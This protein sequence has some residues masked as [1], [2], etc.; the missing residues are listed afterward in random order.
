MTFYNSWVHRTQTQH[1]C[2]LCFH[3]NF[4]MYTD[5]Y[6]CILMY[7]SKCNKPLLHVSFPCTIWIPSRY[8]QHPSSYHA[9]TIPSQHKYL[10]SQI[11]MQPSPQVYLCAHADIAR[12]ESSECPTWNAY[13][14]LPLTSGSGVKSATPERWKSFAYKASNKGTPCE[15]ARPSEDGTS[16]EG[17][18][19][20]CQ[21]DTLP[22]MGWISS[23]EPIC[24]C[25][26]DV[27]QLIALPS[28]TYQPKLNQSFYF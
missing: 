26:S 23:N 22:P 3:F 1:Y 20:K 2:H 21:R 27:M 5:I 25:S 24:C 9:H 28:G 19:K 6:W 11:I 18:R 13:L 17:K 4:P 8:S 7:T 14:L 15:M 12:S 10:L 16:H